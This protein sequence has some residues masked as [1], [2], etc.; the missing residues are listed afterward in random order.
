MKQQ[1]K[2]CKNQ[3]LIYNINWRFGMSNKI[4]NMIKNMVKIPE[5]TTLCEVD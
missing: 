1:G 2:L 3:I 5:K 4:K